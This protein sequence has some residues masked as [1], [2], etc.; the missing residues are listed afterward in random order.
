MPLRA[1]YD[2]YADWYEGWNKPHAEHNA[3]PPCWRRLRG[4]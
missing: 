2:G 1:R 4:S 3:S